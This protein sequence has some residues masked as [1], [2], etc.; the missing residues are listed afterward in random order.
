LH[1]GCSKRPRCSRRGFSSLT[2]NHALLQVF[3]VVPEV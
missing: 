2:K 3:V 1:Y